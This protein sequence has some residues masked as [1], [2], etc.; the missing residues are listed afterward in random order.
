LLMDALVEGERRRLKAAAPEAGIASGEWISYPALDTAANDP[1]ALLVARLAQD[2]RSLA[3]VAFGSEAGVSAQAG[4]T[5]LVCGPGNMARA[6]TAD[7]WIGFDELRAMSAM[8]DGLAE[9]VCWA[10]GSWQ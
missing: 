10:D 8:M 5:A 6:D 7:E 2:S 9:W 1:A 3:A 4:I